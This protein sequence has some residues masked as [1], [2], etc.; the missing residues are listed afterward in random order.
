MIGEWIDVGQLLNGLVFYVVF[1]YSTVAHEAAHAWAAWKG[2]DPTAYRGGQASLDPRPH[3]RREPFGMIVL[4]LLSVVVSG[5]PIGFATAP[6]DARWAERHPDR[7]GRMALAGPAANL[8]LVV[9]AGLAINLGVAF[10]V[11]YPPER[12]AFADVTT[13]AAGADSLWNVVGFLIGSVFAMNVLL[14]VFNLLPVP[15]LDGSGVL[16]L[17]LP[18]ESKA[19]YQKALNSSPVLSMVGIV[20]AWQLFEIVFGPAFNVALNTLY[21]LTGTSYG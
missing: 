20:V 8:A 11:F 7:A 21:I 12:I 1:V 4:P 17:V 2:G 14:L 9:L 6:Y 19:R 16:V 10:G 18:K 13:A 5:W 15:P 3:L